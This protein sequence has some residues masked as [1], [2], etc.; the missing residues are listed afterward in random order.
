MF[1]FSL[2][3]FIFFLANF[4]QVRTR[5]C[6]QINWLNATSNYHENITISVVILNW[7]RP[8]NVK[9]IVN[10]MDKYPEVSEILVIMCLE[11]TKFHVIS[12]K[13]KSLDFTLLELQWGL[14]SRFRGCQIALNQWVLIV[15]DDLLVTRKGLL[16]L[17]SEKRLTPDRLI[18]IWG[19]DYDEKNPQYIAKDVLPNSSAKIALTR[20]VLL[21]YRFCHAFFQLNFLMEDFAKQSHVY[22]NG[23]DIF[24]SLVSNLFLNNTPFIIGDDLSYYQDFNN[25]KHVGIS[26]GKNHYIY[27][28]KFLIKAL[29]KLTCVNNKIKN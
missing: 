26:L 25:Y 11:S 4:T 5:E 6:S 2:F 9:L 17:I 21:D 16:K 27:R 13:A 28:N 1:P 3:F 19:R 14:T 24:I 7:K 15:D 23:E 29:K 12:S 10:E 18:A 20:A 22:W 8:E